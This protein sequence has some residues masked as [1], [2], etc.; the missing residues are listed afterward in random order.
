MSLRSLIKRKL[1]EAAGAYQPNH[2]LI[3]LDAATPFVSGADDDPKNDNDHLHVFIHEYW[4]YWHN[5]S[6]VSGFKSF[7]FTQ[8]LLAHFGN[9]LLPRADGTSVGGGCLDPSH[10]DDVATLLEL[11]LDLDGD[12]APE[13][14]WLSDF[15]LDFSVKAVRETDGELSYQG[16]RKAPNPHVMLDVEVTW[17]DGRRV[18]SEMT[19]GSLAIE[20]S[21]AFLV[22]EQV[23]AGLPRVGYEPPPA[24]P[25]RV[26]ERVYEHLVG[27]ASSPYYPAA[28]GTLGLLATHPG[29][30]FVTFVQMFK[31][32]RDGGLD[33]E[34]ALARV[35]TG[36]GQALGGPID[37][38]LT[39]DLSELVDMHSGRGLPEGALDHVSGLFQR[40]LDLRKQDP[41]FDL[42]IVFPRGNAAA[43]QAH[44]SAFP[45][46]DLLQRNESVIRTL[47]C[48]MLYTASTRLLKT[49]TVIGQATSRGPSKHSKISSTLMSTSTRPS[50]Q[51]RRVPILVVHTSALAICH[52]E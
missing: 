20:E 13:P 40:A 44:Q 31:K 19:L 10:A 21:I 51:T 3:T 12:G 16:G 41:L 45:P 35:I 11:S 33:D 6:T 24:F 9:T 1:D 22:E 37:P 49:N 27:P 34:Q 4:H 25:Y 36:A 47:S 43:L 7:A 38:I 17:P 23:R 39:S 8:H 46:C 42:Q 14:D 30:A 28:L 15:D 48:V 18:S 29:L 52:G 26:V 2:F 5:I 50:S 32:A